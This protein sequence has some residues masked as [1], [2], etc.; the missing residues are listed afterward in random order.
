MNRGKFSNF[1]RNGELPKSIHLPWLLVD[2]SFKILNVSEW[3][4]QLSGQAISVLLNQ[5]ISKVFPQFESD[6]LAH[7]NKENKTITFQ[8]IGPSESY[9]TIRLCQQEDSRWAVMVLP[10]TQ[11]FKLKLQKELPP[12]NLGSEEWLSRIENIIYSPAEDILCT[13][14]EQVRSLMKSEISCIH[15]CDE[16]TEEIINTEWSEGLRGEIAEL[17]DISEFPWNNVKISKISTIENSK[18]FYIG[19]IHI[20]N[21]MCIPII[22]HSHLVGIIGVANRKEDFTEHDAHLVQVFATIVWHTFE[23]PKTMSLLFRQ[24]RVIKKQKE[25]IT[26]SL[27]QLISAVA[28]ALEL[29]DAYTAGHQK[30]VAQLSCLIGEKLGFSQDRIEGLKLGSLIHDI[31]KLA[32]PSDILNK[33]SRLS[34]Q[35]YALVKMHPLQGA[36]IIEEVEFPWPIRLMVLQHHERL[37]GS[38]YPY[39]LT[40]DQICD[41]AKII[42]V[43]DVADSMLSH[44]PYRPSRGMLA[45]SEELKRGR[46]KQYSSMVVDACLDILDS[47]QLDNVYYVGNMTLEPLEF[48]DADISL[49]D[50]SHLLN[51]TKNRVAA[52][53]NE[54]KTKILGV[55][56]KEI[57][58][59]WTSPFLD[60]AAERGADRSLLNKRAHQVMEHKIPRIKKNNTLDDARQHLIKYNEDFLIVESE[61]GLPLGLLTWKVLA[62]TIEEINKRSS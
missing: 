45:L 11:D 33:P 32:I 17:C 5:S 48:V 35:E 31:G 27:I 28:E 55:I 46:G 51:S 60:T 29:K 22:Y 43:A 61:D 41:E 50:L 40:A 59:H 14:V 6:F 10:I 25:K 47:Q 13:A 7:S 62:S 9:F 39:G 37:D 15:I 24:S 30:S 58:A 49:G 38:G 57:L 23:L 56:T 19:N 3:F 18:E 54:S 16:K 21:H 12:T 8:T 2:E 1:L 4:Y 26:H 52:I 36:E 20:K 34:E 42:A 44:R 53:L